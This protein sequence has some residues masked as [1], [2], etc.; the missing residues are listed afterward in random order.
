[1]HD[2]DRAREQ[3]LEAAGIARELDAPEVLARAALGFANW[4]RFGMI[5]REAI[6]LLDEALVRLPAEA[7]VLRA[8]TLALLANRL[9][10]LEAQERREEL[11]DEALG[12][13][14]GLADP[15]TLDSILRI[16]P[17]VLCRPES[18]E[19]R[20]ELAA[21][22]VSLAERARNAES[23]ARAHMHRFLALFEL[24]RPA[25]AAAALDAY[26]ESFA[27]LH[28]PW[29]E[30]SLLVVR[31]MLAILDGRLED[32]ELLRAEARVLDEAADPDAESSAIQG[33]L[34]AHGTD[35]FPDADEE[36]LRHS[37]TM[38]P[39]WPIWSAM[40]ARLLI[41]LGREAEA[42]QEFE[43][44][45]HLDFALVPPT[46]DWLATL[47]LL[48]GCA[49]AL[50]D[51]DRAAVL[52]GLLAPYADRTATMDLG[53]AAWGSVSRPLGLL[54]HA[55]GDREQAAAHLERA[56][57]ADIDRG[58]VLWAMRAALAYRDLLPDQLERSAAG[59]ALVEQAMSLARK[60][61]LPVEGVRLAPGG[62]G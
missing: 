4:Q 16:A 54:A 10:P 15:A 18:L 48:A 33:F 21:E 50:G 56:L 12:V 51:A 7:A 31:A 55:M 32:A 44:C 23:L 30:W 41:G 42:R 25:E 20:L 39:G 52:H 26:A 57:T 22:A 49:H 38:Y 1:M 13:A 3:Y 24:G 9:D 46:H 28:Q 35:R 34:I 60:R 11:L 45:A 61:G 5:D 6:Q 27:G 47:V 14:H 58:A 37:A 8:Q 19:R 59:R 36:A 29:F 17:A 62:T 43:A 40:L 53:L 2:I